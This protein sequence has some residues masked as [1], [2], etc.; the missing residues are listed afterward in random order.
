MLISAK[1]PQKRHSYKENNAE[2]GNFLPKKWGM[3]IF[4]VEY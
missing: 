2:M 1:F 4:S 3:G